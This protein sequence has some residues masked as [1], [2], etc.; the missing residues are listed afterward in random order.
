MAIPLMPR[1]WRSATS[2]SSWTT[3]LLGGPRCTRPPT[4]PS[5]WQPSSR[6]RRRALGPV[7]SPGLGRPR[8]ML[9]RCRSRTTSS[10]RPRPSSSPRV[11][12]ATS[13]TSWQ[14]W[15]RTRGKH[16]WR[17]PGQRPPRRPMPRR[18]K[19]PCRSRKMRGGGWPVLV[20]ECVG[21]GS[22]GNSAESP[23]G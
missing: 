23:F 20:A 6:N 13:R 8:S 18:P 10:W 17:R 19:R 21:L 9:R 2:R 16:P 3:Y 14:R 11:A 22:F 12:A 7:G 4:H 5:G 15:L 1:P